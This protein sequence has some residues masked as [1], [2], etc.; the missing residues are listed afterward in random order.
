MGGEV[1]ELEEDVG[2]SIS[3]LEGVM[4]LKKASLRKNSL[5]NEEPRSERSSPYCTVSEYLFYWDVVFDRWSTRMSIRVHRK[6]FQATILLT[7][8]RGLSLSRIY[9][10]LLYKLW[11]LHTSALH[12]WLLKQSLDF[13]TSSKFP[14][15]RNSNPS[16]WACASTLRSLQQ[17]LFS[18]VKG[19]MAQ[20]VSNF[21]KV[22]RMLFYLYPLILGYFWPTSTLLRG[23]MA[24]AIPSLLWTEPQ[25]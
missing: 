14:I 15:Q 13:S 6:A 3:C 11:P 16:C 20:A 19:L 7:Y 1:D 24:L 23:H 17:I 22:R 21:Q 25:I 9:P 10:I 4:M 8:P 12:H 2:W 5:I 18:L